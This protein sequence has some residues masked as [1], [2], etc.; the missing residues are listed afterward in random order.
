[1]NFIQ[2]VGRIVTPPQK[3]VR[4]GNEVYSKMTLEVNQNFKAFEG[5][6]QKDLFNILLWRG[7]SDQI[8]HSCSNQ[9]LV[10]VKGRV[11][12]E[13]QAYHVVAEHIEIL[14]P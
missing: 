3:G 14:K 1:M 10:A 6:I 9:E 8:L 12:I 13:D 2:V 11:I 4:L 7:I 5:H